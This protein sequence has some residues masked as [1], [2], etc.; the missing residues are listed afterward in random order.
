M[1]SHFEEPP[2]HPVEPADIALCGALKKPAS[3]P[4][5]LIQAG[6]MSYT[7]SSS[8]G[9]ESS[10][11]DKSFA[12][13][14][15]QSSE[16][17]ICSTVD[18]DN[19]LMASSDDA[20][21]SEKQDH[22]SFMSLRITYLIVTLVVMLADG[23]QGT[24]LYV[25]YEGYGFTVA[26]LYCLGFVTGGLASPITGPLVDKLGRKKSAILYCL[27]EIFIN[28]L[29]QYPILAGLI[30]SRMIGG[31][32]TNLLSTVFDTWLDTE[33]RRRGIQKKGGYEIIMRDSVIVSNLAAIGSGY[34]AHV[35]AETYGPKGPF[36]GAVAC[37]S[38]ALVVIMFIWAENYGCGEDQELKSM[39]EFMDDA[40]TAFKNDNKVLRLGI[41]QG[42]TCA[43]IQIFIFL[44]SPALRHFATSAPQGSIG[45]DGNGEPAYGLIFG[46]FMAAGVLGG[47]TAP[48]VRQLSTAMM[49]K[50]NDTNVVSQLGRDGEQTNDDRPMAVEALSTICYLA[51]AF[52]LLLPCLLDGEGEHSFSICLVAFLIYEFIVGLYLPCEG[53][54]RSIYFPAE[55]RASILTLPRIVVNCSVSV[56]V[57]LTNYMTM[58][59]AFSSIF[60]LM[61]VSAALQLSL[62]VDPWSP[63]AE[64][65]DETVPIKAIS[66]EKLASGTWDHAPELK[67]ASFV[68]SFCS[69]GDDA[70]VSSASSCKGPAT[71]KLKNE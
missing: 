1:R 28:R 58:R 33:Y 16:D 2:I 42:L 50:Y 14:S 62:V 57:V 17:S 52:L 3:L 55:G 5:D 23:L 12:T 20:A 54:L 25:L 44:W 21:T 48:W 30:I 39:R 35:L 9:D 18:E 8:Q 56:G 70:S 69:Q 46:A 13:T 51:S 32:T 40:V 68:S 49:M 29:E 10:L 15:Q 63:I 36:E 31:I 6:S 24:H 26:N 60:V 47:L 67:R 65:D 38:I 7:S 45:L 37:T 66:G 61:V 43:S 64:E 22:A 59:D 53:V 19:A 41:I 34:L 71:D 27:L 4:L 11:S